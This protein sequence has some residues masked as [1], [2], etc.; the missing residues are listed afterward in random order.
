MIQQR[1]GFIGRLAVVLVAVGLALGTVF[2][3]AYD[4]GALRFGNSYKLQAIIPTSASL[5]P[6][7][8]VTMAGAQVGLVTGVKQYGDGALVS[9]SIS[10]KQVTPLPADSRVALRY[11]T[12]IGENYVEID[13]GTSKTMLVS[14]AILPVSQAAPYVDVD[15]LMSVLQGSTTQRTRELIE[16]LGSALATRGPQ[17]NST[18][19]GVS[20]TFAPLA[21]I[22]QIMHADQTQSDDLVQYLGDIAS[23][24]GERGASI[25]TLAHDALTTFKAVGVQD[26]ALSTTFDE[27]PSTLSQVRETADTL[28]S[29]TNTAA[30]VVQKLADTVH[31]LR[32]AIQSLAPAASEGRQVLSELQKA[33]PGL[34]TTLA[35]LRSLSGPTV[36]ALPELTRTLCQVNPML[37]Y[38]KPYTGDVISFLSWFGSAVNAYD[39]IG[40]LVRLVPIVGDDSVSGLP[41]GV[42]TAMFELL[43]AGLLENTTALNW[44]P[45]PAPG[46]IGKE[47]ATGSA[48]AIGP[49]DLKAK[50]GYTYPHVTADCTA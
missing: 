31:D 1:H 21:N 40:H 20:K 41:A 32:P 23:A 50:T 16:A 30:P 35:R 3:L 34:T 46:Q 12:P 9:M 18:L 17:L 6:G 19:G 37:K 27:L 10:D 5:I 48:E 15:Q 13:P 29:A 14:G 22:V 43:H 28:N 2:G 24:A 45:Y 4:G 36:R 39:D 42:S 49:F 47:S 33:A 8:R 7:A 11:V 44:D 25:M 38:V 26:K